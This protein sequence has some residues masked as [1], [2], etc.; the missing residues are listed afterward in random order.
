MR[1]RGYLAVVGAA[2]VLAGVAVLVEP[3]LAGLIGVRA[4]QLVVTALALL[5]VLQGLAAVVG[6]LAGEGRAATPPAVE[7]RFPAT[8][9]GSDFDDLLADLPDLRVQ[10]RNEERA[11]VRERLEALAIEVLVARGLDETAARRQLE[12]GTWTADERA[13]SLFV[14]AADRELSVGTRLRDAVSSDLAFTRRARHAV[15]AIAA[16][17]N[18]EVP[19]PGT[20]GP[21]GGGPVDGQQSEPPVTARSDD[22]NDAVG[23]GDHPGSTA[24]DGGAEDE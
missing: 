22:G 17:A 3:G 13:A 2:A 5:A 23:T 21:A 12:A 11:A 18:R 16:H 24:A 20:R 14:P 4:D 1:A 9:P 8:V 6:R 15:A 10:R 19:P 7:R